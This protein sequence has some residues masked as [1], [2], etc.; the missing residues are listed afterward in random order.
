MYSLRNAITVSWIQILQ[1]LVTGQRL[2][3]RP[4]LLYIVWKRIFYCVGFQRNPVGFLRP[5]FLAFFGPFTFFLVWGIW[6]FKFLPAF[7]QAEHVFDFFS[8]PSL[9]FG[10]QNRVASLHILLMPGSPNCMALSVAYIR[11]FGMI[12]QSS[13]TMMHELA[14]WPPFY[15]R[16]GSSWWCFPLGNSSILWILDRLLSLWWAFP[17]LTWSPFR[18]I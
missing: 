13:T 10:H 2:F 18:R 14:F 6:N 5:M 3:F 8:I 16:W 7:R 4:Q 17:G 12:I 1:L 15:S 11:D 9:M